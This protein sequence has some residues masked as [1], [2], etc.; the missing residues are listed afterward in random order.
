MTEQKKFSLEEIR[1]AKA[2]S[3]MKTAVRPAARAPAPPR[4]Y[5]KAVGVFL[6]LTVV[7]AV[8]LAGHGWQSWSGAL[9]RADKAL[10]SGVPPGSPSMPPL[11][12]DRELERLVALF[13]RPSRIEW[14]EIEATARL[15]RTGNEKAKQLLADSGPYVEAFRAAYSGELASVV[16]VYKNGAGLLNST[17]DAG[18]LGEL[19]TTTA[20]LGNALLDKGQADA[21]L[22]VLLGVIRAG[23]TVARGAGG[24]YG[25]AYWEAGRGAASTA[26]LLVLAN[27]YGGTVAAGKLAGL[28]ERLRAT[29]ALEPDMRRL[30]ISERDLHEAVLERFREELGVWWG[31][32]GLAG[33]FDPFPSLREAYASA[34]GALGQA[35]K[36]AREAFAEAAASLRRPGALP[37][38]AHAAGPLLLFEPGLRHYSIAV[39]AVAGID[40]LER[41]SH[42]KVL[43]DTLDAFSRSLPRD[44]LN[45]RPFLYQNL[46]DGFRLWGV[47]PDLEDNGGDETKDVVLLGAP[48]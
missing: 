40:V 1:A 7:T 37:P 27:A 35:P 39:G 25:A 26:R 44:P 2:R 5:R 24:R 38:L 13:K 14:A 28:R 30:L 23:M 15:R 42:D 36:V 20:A 34:L 43:P 4:S 11:A 33:H 31:S 22:D 16:E 29:L 3:V 10:D 6:A 19:L 48:K 8:A 32:L 47:G 9:A 21:G 46:G 41:L 12:S 18:R 45:D 17:Y